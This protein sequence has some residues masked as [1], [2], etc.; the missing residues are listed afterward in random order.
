MVKV[1]RKL[2]L[3]S[4]QKN[5]GECPPQSLKRVEHLQPQYV[6][7]W[8]REMETCRALHPY[9]VLEDGRLKD[10]RILVPA[11]IFQQRRHLFNIS[12]CSLPWRRWTGGVEPRILLQA[13]RSRQLKKNSRVT[14]SLYIDLETVGTLFCHIFIGNSRGRESQ[15]SHGNFT[16]LQLT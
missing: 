15:T 4:P 8:S 6:S 3:S 7:F 16:F 9:T 11:K 13:E 2:P 1:S 10:V 12:G 5:S 14:V